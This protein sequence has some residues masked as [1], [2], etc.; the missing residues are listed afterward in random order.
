MDRRE[1]RD[2]MSQDSLTIMLLTT[3]ILESTSTLLICPQKRQI[4]RP[5]YMK[6]SSVMSS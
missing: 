5:G 4:H 6:W 1:A 3:I 2:G